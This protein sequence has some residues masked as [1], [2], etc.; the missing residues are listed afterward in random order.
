MLVVVWTLGFEVTPL[1][2]ALEHA[3]NAADAGAATHCHGGSCHDDGDDGGGIGASEHGADTLAHRDVAALS[4]IGAIVRWPETMVA[5][6][7]DVV[8]LDACSSTGAATVPVAR[9][10]PRA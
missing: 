1:A 9:G 3:R 8:A 10:P 2:H 4:P 6:A 7:L 5:P